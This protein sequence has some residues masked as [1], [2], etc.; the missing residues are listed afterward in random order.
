[1]ANSKNHFQKFLKTESIAS[2]KELAR[3][4]KCLTRNKKHKH[5][6]VNSD[7]AK[8]SVRE[9]AAVQ[10]LLNNLRFDERWN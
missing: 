2:F 10:T 6:A 9:E 5:F 3:A 8:S 4:Q 1:M 7:V